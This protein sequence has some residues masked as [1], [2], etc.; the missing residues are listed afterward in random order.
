MRF[1]DFSFGS[2]RIDGTA[3]QHDVVIDRGEVR[4]RKKKASK[5]FRDDFGHTPLSLAEKIPLEMPPA[6][7]RHRRIRQTAGDEGSAARSRA[8]QDRIARFSDGQSNRG[9]ESRL[10]GYQRH[11]ACDVLI[12]G[13][14]SGIYLRRSLCSSI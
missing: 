9:V 13:K 2:L 4:R 11:P 3:Y 10:R 14:V 7:G 8:P 1:E 6:G 5:K 12:L